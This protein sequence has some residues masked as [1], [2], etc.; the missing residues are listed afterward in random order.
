M[1][2]EF[3]QPLNPIAPVCTRV[4][5]RLFTRVQYSTILASH[6]EIHGL[7]WGLSSGG[8]GGTGA[9]GLFDI[10]CI[11]EVGLQCILELMLVSVGV[12]YTAGQHRNE[13]VDPYCHSSSHVG[14]EL[15]RASGVLSM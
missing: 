14:K 1:R 2:L 4:S 12:E 5:F 9:N 13:G 15:G 7:E 8:I 10:R 6:P 11:W 3:L